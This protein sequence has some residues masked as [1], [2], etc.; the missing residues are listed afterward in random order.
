M[1][2]YVDVKKFQTLRYSK[3]KVANGK[4][5]WESPRLSAN[6]HDIHPRTNLYT[7]RTMILYVYLRILFWIRLLSLSICSRFSR[8]NI[9][10]HA[11]H[12]RDGAETGHPSAF[13]IFVSIAGRLWWPARARENIFPGGSWAHC[14]CTS[15]HS[16][17]LRHTFTKLNWFSW[18]T[19]VQIHTPRRFVHRRV[20]WQVPIIS[21]W[22]GVYK[23]FNNR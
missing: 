17:C 12:E 11:S 6:K 13:C 2:T 16:R 10:M 19:R 1:Y 7:N 9:F 21:P 3:L 4:R 22:R 23:M 18:T 14:G 5:A 8:E 15:F 20:Q